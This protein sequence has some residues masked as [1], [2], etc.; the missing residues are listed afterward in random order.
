MA[1]DELYRCMSEKKVNY[2]QARESIYGVL[3]E[4]D[5]CL[6]VAEIL[7]KVVEIYPRKISLNTIYRHLN[8]F[9]DCKLVA[10]I[11]DNFKKAHYCHLTQDKPRVFN[12][13]SKCNYVGRVT[14]DSQ[15]RVEVNFLLGDD[16]A[17]FVTLHKTCEDCIFKRR[18]G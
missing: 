3:L 12:I 17:A 7:E 1:L 4:S 11:Q 6:S 2:S 13:C 14:I 5:D 18:E 15:K 8:L 16:Q 9:V 10:A